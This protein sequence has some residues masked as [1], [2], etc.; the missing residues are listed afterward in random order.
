MQMSFTQMYIAVSTITVLFWASVLFM[1]V[2]LKTLYSVVSSEYF[3]RLIIFL[4]LII[5]KK[6]TKKVVETN[7]SIQIRNNQNYNYILEK[8][9]VN[10]RDSFAR[11]DTFT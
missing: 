8:P 10:A 11:W 9:D 2:I 5:L 7:Q 3:Q 4:S 1:S 6:I